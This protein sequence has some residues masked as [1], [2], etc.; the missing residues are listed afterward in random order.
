MHGSDTTTFSRQLLS[1]VE[2][3]LALLASND[4]G[5]ARMG[6]LH[7]NTLGEVDRMLSALDAV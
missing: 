5:I 4:E 1:G 2:M 3:D 6:L 7:Y